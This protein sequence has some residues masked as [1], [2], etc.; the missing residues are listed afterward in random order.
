MRGQR[1]GVR[2]TKPATEQEEE[3]KDEDEK[4]EPCQDN[5]VITIHNMSRTL[6][7]NQNGKLLRTS[8]LGNKYQMILHKINSNST[9]FEPMKNLTEGDIIIA[10]KC[11]LTRIR[12]C[13][14]KPKH[15]ILD[16]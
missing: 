2:S 4:L 8:R 5:I 6:Y 16:K 13:G 10:R 7:T 15:Q 1:Q 14:L 3:G 12:L 11:G 9:W